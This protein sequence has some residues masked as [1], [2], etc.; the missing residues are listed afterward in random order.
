MFRTLLITI[1]TIVLLS[2]C[3]APAA[4]VEPG[5]DDP[6]SSPPQNGYPAPVEEPAKFEPRDSDSD[7]ERGEVFIDSTDMLIMESY[8]VQIMLVLKGNAPTPCH[9]VRIMANPPDDQNNI[10]VEV[11]SVFDPEQVCIQILEPI[12][13]NFN[14]GSF[15]TGSYTVFVNGEKVGEFES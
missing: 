10:Q 5:A 7:L 4:P 6:A 11:Y 2:A 15:L 14:L 3:T 9:Q 1:L 8:P 12:E 13:A